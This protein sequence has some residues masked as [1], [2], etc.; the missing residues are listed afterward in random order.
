MGCDGLDMLIDI[1]IECLE[2]RV[3]GAEHE[4]DMFGLAWVEK[5]FFGLCRGLGIADGI[6]LELEQGIEGDGIEGALGLSFL[7]K[8]FIE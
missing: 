6:E 7:L 1:V 8:E 5:G 4:W 3:C 2:F